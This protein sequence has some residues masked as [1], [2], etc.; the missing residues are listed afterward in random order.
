M[1]RIKCIGCHHLKIE[2]QPDDF[3]HQTFPRK[4]FGCEKWPYWTSFGGLFR[5]GKGIAGAAERCP[6]DMSACAVC[7]RREALVSFGKG[8]IL[9]LCWEHD[10]AWSAWLNNPFEK[11]IISPRGKG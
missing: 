8:P 3:I 5:P 4:I 7:G 10:D 11:Q 2:S 1:S 6:E 9:Y